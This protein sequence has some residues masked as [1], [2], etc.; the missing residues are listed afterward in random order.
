M[1]AARQNAVAHRD[2]EEDQEA[3]L[4]G[5]LPLSIAVGTVVELARILAAT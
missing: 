4:F 1:V 5:G 2:R 3:L